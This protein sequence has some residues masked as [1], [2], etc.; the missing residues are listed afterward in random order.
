MK[1]EDIEDIGLG[2]GA[3]VMVAGM[4]IWDSAPIRGTALCLIGMG[5]G[6]WHAIRG[7]Y[8]MW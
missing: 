3:A 8:W 5:I 4:L 6:A 7:G 1:K 2:I